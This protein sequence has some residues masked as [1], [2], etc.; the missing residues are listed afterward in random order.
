[1][2][3]MGQMENQIVYP[4]MGVA[5]EQPQMGGMFPPSN[6]QIMGGMFPPSNPQI[7]GGKILNPPYP[8]GSAQIVIDT[9]PISM[10]A[11]GLIPGGLR[12]PRRNG[13]RSYGGQG[14]GGM[15]Q[16]MGGMGQ[17]MGQGESTSGPTQINIIKHE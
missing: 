9:S 6:P 17:G 10:A 15:G 12:P 16:G 11:D 5:S 13:F 3:Q 14:M 1:M 7:M 2:G 4:P 8:H